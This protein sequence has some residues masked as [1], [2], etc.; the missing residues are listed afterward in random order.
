MESDNI[1]KKT[2][3]RINN[4]IIEIKNITEF[5]IVKKKD[6]WVTVIA[7]AIFIL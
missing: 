1:E 7:A 5:A 4:K 2:S 6:E 3:I